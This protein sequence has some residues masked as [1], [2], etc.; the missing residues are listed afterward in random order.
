MSIG[1]SSGTYGELWQGPLIDN[2]GIPHIAILTFPSVLYSTVKLELIPKN[3]IKKP[4]PIP[5]KSRKAL[6]KVIKKFQLDTKIDNYH[7]SRKTELLTSVGMSSSTADIISTIKA[8]ANIH[9]ILL[10]PNDFQE[11]LLGIERSD[12]K[13]LVAGIGSA[14]PFEN[15]DYS[16]YE[17]IHWI[18]SSL[19]VNG[20]INLLKESGVFG[21]LSTGATY[22]VAK[23]LSHKNPN[24]IYIMP[25]ADTGHRYI[26]VYEEHYH[27]EDIP[28]PLFI[29]RKE[30]L[31]MPWSYTAWS[32]K[33]FPYFI[34]EYSNSKNIY[35]CS[36]SYYNKT[37]DSR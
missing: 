37:G 13:M 36:T 6:L 35:K 16:S 17:Y 28:E 7:W 18:A 24:N 8:V 30:E 5:S 21:G 2:K 1:I 3:S 11:I 4:P 29:N 26:K 19:A 10:K 25:S 27:S 12:P 31:T 23:Y 14:I 20:G 15:I 9:N 33:S 32:E 22:I 34:N